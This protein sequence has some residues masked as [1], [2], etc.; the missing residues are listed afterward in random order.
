MIKYSNNKDDISKN[1]EDYNPNKRQKILIVFDDKIV[2]MLSNKKLNPAVTEL[3][4]RGRKLEV[5]LVFITQSHFA[6]PKDIWLNSA[7]YFVMK[8]PNKREFWQIVFNH[9]SDIDFQDLMNLYKKCTAKSYSFF[10]I[11]TNL[12]SHNFLSFRENLVG[13]I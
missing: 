13:R 9:S 7:H 10:I 2:D 4:I 3:F 11:D 8:I 12:T 1:I 5:F 6:I